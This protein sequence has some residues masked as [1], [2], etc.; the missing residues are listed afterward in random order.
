MR[1]L[2]TA[3]LEHFYD[4]LINMP[5]IAFGVEDEEGLYAVWGLAFEAGHWWAFFDIERKPEGAG[6]KLLAGIRQ[7]KR[8]ADALGIVPK[9]LRNKQFETSSRVVALAGFEVVECQD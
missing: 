5:V 1:V 7:V 4:K 6:P 9:V 2:A 8:V 3:E